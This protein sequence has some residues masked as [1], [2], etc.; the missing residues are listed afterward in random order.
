MKIG[1]LRIKER[2]SS[3][4]AYFWEKAYRHSSYRQ[5]L[6]SRACCKPIIDIM[7]VVEEIGLLD[8]SCIASMAAYGYEAKGENGI[9]GRSYFIK[10]GSSRTHHVHVYGAA[11]PEIERHLAFRD[12]LIAHPDWAASYGRLKQEL[13]ALHPWDIAA[14]INGKEALALEIDRLAIAWQNG[15]HITIFYKK[16]QAAAISSHHPNGTD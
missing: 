13:A 14:Y 12:Y 15:S 9:S 11:S 7:P 5:H 16:Q 6:R 10:G 2:L 8:A 3:S 4:G 1:Q